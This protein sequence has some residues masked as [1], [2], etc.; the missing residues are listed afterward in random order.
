MVKYIGQKTDH[1]DHSK[2]T[3]PQ[4]PV[5]VP[6]SPP[7]TPRSCS[8]CRTETPSPWTPAP[9]APPPPALGTHRSP[10]HVCELDQ[11]G[12]SCKWNFTV[13]VFL[14]PA[15]FTQHLVLS[16]PVF[17]LG[18]SLVSC[19]SSLRIPDITPLPDVR[20]TNTVSCSLGCL[21]P[22]DNVL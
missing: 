6:R 10:F 1:R 15:Y 11:S 19:R 4:C 21:F 22:L 18:F 9:H 8:V 17:E 14:L 3:A 20:F 2:R 7:S 5:G 12:C 16:I 13:P